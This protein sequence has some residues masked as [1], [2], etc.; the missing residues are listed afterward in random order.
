MFLTPSDREKLLL[1]VAGMVARDRLERG[2]RLNH[3]EAVALLSCWAIE[4]AREG[5]TVKG[6]MDECVHVLSADQV[7]DGVPELVDYVQVEATFPDGRKLVTMTHPIRHAAGHA[8]AAETAGAA[9]S[10]PGAVV[11]APGEIELNAGREKRSVVIRNDG[12]RPVQIGSHIHL[13][14]V[15]PALTFSEADGTPA[16]RALVDG[17]R[18]DIPAGTSLR[19]QPGDEKAV[20]AVRLGGR[21][22]VPGIRPAKAVVGGGVR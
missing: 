2:V 9:G 17:F 4:R 7:M 13:A 21:R 19:F 14:D 11:P 6:L 1:S 18:L 5:A 12:D 20:T 8:E 16:D 15:N 22:E 3:P 10:A